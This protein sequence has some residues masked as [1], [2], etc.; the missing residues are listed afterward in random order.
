M[1]KLPFNI[2]LAAYSNIVRP[3]SHFAYAEQKTIQK[4]MKAAHAET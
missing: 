3:D 4:S 1:G 2:S